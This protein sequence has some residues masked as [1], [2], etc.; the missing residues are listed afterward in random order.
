M[1]DFGP[2]GEIIY[3]RTYS[4]YLPDLLRRENWEETVDR[5]VRFSVGLAPTEEWEE[6]SLK[7]VLLDLK[8]FTAGRTL[9]IGGTPYAQEDNGQAQFN[10]AFMDVEEPKDFHDMVFL[11]MSGVGVGFRATRDNVEKLNN[12]LPIKQ[13]AEVVVQPY[14]FYGYDHHSYSHRTAL[15]Y[16]PFDSEMHI[17]VGDSREGWAEAV[18]AFLKGV[19]SYR[20][21]VIDVNRVRPMGERLKTFG[22]YASGPEPLIEFFLTVPKILEREPHGRWSSTKILD[23]MNL[24]GRMVVAGGT[25]RSA[26]IA[27]GDADDLDFV[28]AKTGDWWSKYPWRTQSNNTVIFHS[29]PD[30]ETLKSL[31]E[32][33]LQYGEPGLLNAEAASKRRPNFRGINPC[34]AGDTL[35]PVPGQGLVFIAE[36]AD[37]TVPVVDGNGNVVMAKAEKTGENQPLLLVRLSD[38]SEYKVTPWHEFV[39]VDGSKRQA[40][41]LQPGDELMPPKGVEGAFGPIHDPDRA[42]VDAWLIA[43]GTWHNQAHWAKLYLYPP[44]HKYRDA[45]ERA[46][47]R[48]FVGPDGKNRYIMTFTGDRKALPKDRVPDYVLRGDRDTVL[49]FIRGYLEADGHVKKSKTKGW[50]VQVVSVHKSF[51]QQLQA[52]LA[53]LGVHSSI[54]KLRNGGKHLM[55]DGNGGYKE[56]NTRT[57]YRLTVSNPTKLVAML[58]WDTP[59]RGGYNVQKKVHVVAVEDTGERADVYC[60]G[61]PT[62]QSFDLPTCHSG[63]C[64]EILLDNNGF[65]NLVTVV[66]PRHV[67]DGRLDLQDLEHTIRVLTR[68]AIRITMV[69]FPIHLK[70]WAEVQYRDRLLGVSFTGYGDLVDMLELSE[71]E[72]KELLSWMRRVV[73]EEAQTYSAQL[74]INP[75]LLAT[76][77]KPEGTL[78]LLPGVSSGVHPSYAPYYIRRVRISKMD[79]VAQALKDLGLEPK[80]EVG[81]DSLEEAHTWV[82]EFPIK[83]PAKKAMHEYSAVEQLERYKLVN[84]Y[85]TDHN[86]SIT[87][88]IRPD[89]VDQ[90]VDWLLENWDHYVAVS[91]LPKSDE[92]YPLMPFEQITKKQYEKM[93]AKM[94]DLR[95]L[96]LKLDMLEQLGAMV[97][98]ELDPSC[99]T[100]VCPTR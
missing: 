13:V 91:F 83:T 2:I 59:T 5:V 53:M 31:M 49:A 37:K 1:P 87:V 61:V 92:V 72:Q 6:S 75:P 54:A 45:I 57:T 11:L 33:I 16:T 7:Q 73:H 19:T 40:K 30:R 60:V 95:L 12:T 27:L 94:P 58:G 84:S 81:F 42:Y 100:G 63:N 43:D 86:T 8:G 29:K 79:A 38:G 48:K 67:K 89:E 15:F 55:P 35:V 28:E 41:D 22:G 62:T 77:V 74:G 32:K 21:V 71:E 24:I 88:Y 9:W 44:K 3:L 51:L 23:I 46:A 14:N 68:H 50:L 76:T 17:V 69:K 66:L 18:Q 20:R 36:L 56:Y 52:L 65:C 98:D 96:K 47:G 93:V 10:C 64:A 78:S 4:R 90:V 39:L 85:Y 70:E 80:P 34:L 97:S 25:R 26:Q 99:D 82:F